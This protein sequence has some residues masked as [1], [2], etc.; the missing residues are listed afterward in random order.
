MIKQ[1]IIDPNVLQVIM[2]SNDVDY[3]ADQYNKIQIGLFSTI[4][5]TINEYLK[6]VGIEEKIEEISQKKKEE[7]SPE[8]KIILESN[9]LTSL[10]EKNTQT[11]YKTLLDQFWPK[12]SDEDKKEIEDYMNTLPEI[13]EEQRKL[14][15]DTADTLEFLM[16]QKAAQS[17]APTTT[18]TNVNL[19]G[20]LSNPS[21]EKPENSNAN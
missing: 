17:N 7:V 12:L 6:K 16:K 4:N 21:Q 10:V 19:G 20:N 9:E 8:I 5:S 13:Y 15:L 14:F 11:F 2:K 1:Y 3:I 18:D